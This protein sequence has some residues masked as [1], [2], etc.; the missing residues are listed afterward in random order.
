MVDLNEMCLEVHRSPGYSP[1]VAPHYAEVKTFGRG[2]SVT[3]LASPQ[4]AIK[5]ADLLPMGE[6]Q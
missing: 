3:P 1:G 2:D 5:V 6:G 4:S